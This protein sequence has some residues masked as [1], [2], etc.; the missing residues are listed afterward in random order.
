M[1]KVPKW[2]NVRGRNDARAS[3][4]TTV[5]LQAGQ[6]LKLSGRSKSVTTAPLEDS[7]KRQRSQASRVPGPARGQPEVLTNATRRL[8]DEDNKV[9]EL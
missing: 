6:W 7:I 1:K 2:E 8:D 5:A 4:A 3:P 9:D